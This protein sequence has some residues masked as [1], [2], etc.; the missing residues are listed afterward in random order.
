M[1]SCVYTGVVAKH[2]SVGRPDKVPMYINVY[3]KYVRESH[4]P[5]TECFL[6]NAKSV[7]VHA[8]IAIINI[9]YAIF[10]S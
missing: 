10:E 3:V 4:P 7:R 6:R 9:I 5:S 2:E 1:Y 8:A